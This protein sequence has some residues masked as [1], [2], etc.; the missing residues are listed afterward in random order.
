MGLTTRYACAA[1]GYQSRALASGGMMSG[2][3]FEVFACGTCKDLFSAEHGMALRWVAMRETTDEKLPPCPRCHR[4]ESV[5]VLRPMR[6]P[7]E[8]PW[9]SGR[10][11]YPCPSCGAPECQ[12]EWTGLSD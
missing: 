6:E 4:A 3:H 1:C 2:S 9:R 10:T 11:R 8:S 5:S 7:G 12:S